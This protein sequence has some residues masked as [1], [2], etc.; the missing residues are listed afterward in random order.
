M[1]LL[2][3]DNA[4]RIQHEAVVLDLGDLRRQADQLREQAEAEATQIIEQARAEARRLTDGA[5]ERGH[6]QG[7]AAGHA[8]GLERGQAEGRAAALE[9]VGEQLQQLQQA[10]VAAA[11]QWEADR[12]Q[13]VLDARESMLELAIAIARRVVKRIP[14]VDASVVVEQVVAAI[15]HM[16]RPA[17]ATIRIHPDDREL[18]EQAM[19]EMAQ[20]CEHLQH[21]HWVDDATIE[22]GGCVVS[23]GRGRIDAQLATQLDR[24][25]AQLLPAGSDRSDDN[26]NAG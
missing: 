6:A 20:A 24:V 14:A 19:P 4:K 9:Q 15:D 17:D 11:R 10:W 26:L 21:V 25:I 23:A 12:R 7:L 1:P 16:A 22:R 3:N 5:A 2:K 18:A 13:M 8:E